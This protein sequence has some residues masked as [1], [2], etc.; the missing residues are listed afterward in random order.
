[1]DE[2]YRRVLAS[3]VPRSYS[4]RV[5]VLRPSE[6]VSKSNSSLAPGRAVDPTL[7]W[8]KVAAEVDV[9]E[10]PGGYTTSLTRYVDI[11]A[12]RIRICLEK[13]ETKV[14]PV[15]NGMQTPIS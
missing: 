6:I 5:A 11:L 8:R 14:E 2:A 9:Y 3:Y 13:V 1:L 15:V 12:D 4:G 7:G 10:V